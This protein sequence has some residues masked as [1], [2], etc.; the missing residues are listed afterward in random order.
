MRKFVEDYYNDLTELT[1]SIRVTDK[2]GERI[3][4]SHGIEKVGNLILSQAD[5]GHKLMFIG[6]GA[7]ATISSHM[8]TDFWKTCGVRAVAFNDSSLLTCLGNDFGYE[9][10]FEK[11]IE[12]FADRG[13][14]LV[15]ISSS[16]KSENILRGVNSAKSKDCSVITLSGFKDDN[17][18][19]SAGDYN[20]YVPAQEY[21]P[22]EVIH[23][24]ICHCI[25]DAIGN[26]KERHR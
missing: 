6:N 19:S 2:E 26:D 16:G 11:S 10:I 12:M 3:K 18:L 7:S 21:G 22:V 15:A 5:S 23:H 25:L 13:D 24:S 1:R 9:Y 20:F 4:F 14:I 17:P 8:S